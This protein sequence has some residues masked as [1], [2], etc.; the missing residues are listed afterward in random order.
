[1]LRDARCDMHDIANLVEH[2]ARREAPRIEANDYDDVRDPML[3]RALRP[4]YEQGA[5]V[6]LR[7]AREVAWS[8]YRAAAGVV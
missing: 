7:V 1:V 8:A 2:S 3:P 5:P 6:H 4:A